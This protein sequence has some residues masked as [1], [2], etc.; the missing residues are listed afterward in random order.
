M[1]CHPHALTITEHPS[2][3]KLPGRPWR[4]AF[5]VLA[6][7]SILPAAA[8][9]NA[10]DTDTDLSRAPRHALV[11]GNSTYSV[12]PLVNPANDAPAAA[13]SV[14]SPSSPFSY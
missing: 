9:A 1:S 4:H 10:T 3:N 5:A 13:P 7:T 8:L 14:T 6:M 11:I 2:P 12:G